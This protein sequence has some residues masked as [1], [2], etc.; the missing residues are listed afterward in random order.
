LDQHRQ[1]L[2]HPKG[3]RFDGRGERFGRALA[4]RRFGRIG[5][6]DKRKGFAPAILKVS[7][8]IYRIRESAKV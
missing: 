4:R 3:F 1:S 7:I 6:E 2:E 8:E 5:A